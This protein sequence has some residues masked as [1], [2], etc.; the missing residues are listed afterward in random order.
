MENK[1][2]LDTFRNQPVDPEQ[3]DALE[4]LSGQF[5]GLWSAI[6]HRIPDG[7]NK[8]LAY[9]HLEDALHRSKKAVILRT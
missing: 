8:T 2:T 5:A 7:P 9:R 6:A 3:C 1:L 4:L